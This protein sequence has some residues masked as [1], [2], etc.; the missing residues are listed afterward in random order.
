MNIRVLYSGR[1]C[2]F[3]CLVLSLALATGPSAAVVAQPPVSEPPIVDVPTADQPIKTPA[4]ERVGGDKTL[5]AAA[6]AGKVDLS[7]VSPQAVALIVL[8]PAQLLRA[9]GSEY[10]PHEVLTVAGT[11]HLGIDPA[12][13]SEV[14]IFVDPPM[15]FQPRFGVA[16]KFVEPFSMSKLPEQLR[17]HTQPGELAG[18]QYLQSSHPQ[19]PSL[20]MPNDRTLLVAPDASLRQ[21][22]AVSEL[23]QTSPLFERVRGVAVASELYAVVDVA[24]LRPMIMPMVQMAIA[25][26]GEK[27]PAEA[28]PFVELPNLISS[29]ELTVNLMSAGPNSLVAHANDAAS[30]DRIEELIDIAHGMRQQAME[31][32]IAKLAASE[33]PI[34]RALAQYMQRMSTATAESIRPA[35]EADS[36]VLFRLAGSDGSQQDKLVKVAVIGVLVALLLPAVQAAREAARRS[37]SQNNLKH[38]MLSMHNYADTHKMFPAHASYSADGKPL[39]SWRVHVLPFLEEIELY[40]QFHLDEPWDSEHNLTL[41]AQMPAVFA[42]PNLDSEP[43]KTNYLGVVGSDCIFDGTEKGIW[44]TKI[45]DGTSK[46]IMLVEADADRA[47]IWTKPDDFKFDAANPAAGLGGIRPG[48]WLAGFADGS[49]QFIAQSVD[50]ETVKSLFTRAGGEVIGELR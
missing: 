29:V 46:T 36:L 27:F 5:L 1:F 30:A 35:R 50:N 37:Q 32:E 3:T 15:G 19:L 7:Y 8:H 16:V 25:Q 45:S 43:G 41:V 4:R 42:N 24:T 48:G 13:V 39:L 23:Q 31:G 34:E 28:K 9:P 47:V 22:L 10:L 11:Q 12:D 26:Q 38:L 18:Q 40:N 20:Y 14:T 21:M 2:R 17:A 49:V 6:D 33:D 44:F